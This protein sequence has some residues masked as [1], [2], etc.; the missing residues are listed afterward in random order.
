MSLLIGG[1]LVKSL[2]FA[3]FGAG[4]LALMLTLAC[5][6]WCIRWLKRRFRERIASDSARLNELH[7][8]KRDTPTMGGV[9]I[10]GSTVV[11]LLFFAGVSSALVW[12]SCV[13]MLALMLLGG[14][15]DWI[16]QR[17]SKKG[18]TVGQKFL[19][20]WLIAILA[21]VAI[22][23]Q[24]SRSGNTSL[25]IPWTTQ[26]FEPGLFWIPWA[27]FVIV[28]SS[29]AVNLTDGL[30]GLATGCSAITAM[31]LAETIACGTAV[32]VDDANRH[33]AVVSSAALAGSTL[34]FLWWNRHP[35]QVFMGDTGSL[36]IGGLLAIVALS[37]GH[38]LFLA[39]L[40]LVFVAETLSVLIQVAWYR[41]TRRRVL[42]C[43][44]LHNHFVFQG[45][46]EQK[47]VIAFWV[48]AIFAGVVGLTAVSW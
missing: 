18:L 47:I 38:E 5:G 15:D 32:V 7:A 11:S 44:P 26:T 27:A 21:A 31:F 3:A 33:V 35:A 10:V 1:L 40:S 22:L 16:K 43:S 17:T 20:Q 45:V 41:R 14:A 39:I 6:P 46:G 4:L 29:N 24:R 23:I 42:L 12:V 8:S 37:T 28:A 36:P 30:D 25:I 9:L 19:S 48:A 13:T 34:G 2:P